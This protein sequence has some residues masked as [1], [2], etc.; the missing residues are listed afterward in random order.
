MIDRFGRVFASAAVLAGLFGAGASAAR[1]APGF[2]FGAE[3]R[4]WAANLDGDITIDQ[5]AIVG[6]KIDA[7]NTLD[8][9]TSEATL[10]GEVWFRIF[11]NRFT[12]SWVNLENEGTKNLSQSVVF[13]GVTYTAGTTVESRL[14]LNILDGTF[15]RP[16]P[17]IGSWGDFSVNILLGVKKVDFEGEI[18]SP[19][20]TTTETV[21]A[22]L[23]QVGLSFRGKVS[24][25]EFYLAAKGLAIDVGDVSGHMVDIRAEA[26]LGRW[27][28]L[29]VK[30]GYRY[31]GFAIESDDAELDLVY[32]GPYAGLSYEF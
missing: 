20:L 6:T 28:G 13:D 3:L 10:D 17:F 8:I 30:G 32:S 4:H 2:G 19:V 9:D 22:P 26:G 29:A 21:E 7:E 18:S 25:V 12:F 16:L 5:N 14:A 15:E 27:Y 1:A 24:P 11:S 23:P 31:L